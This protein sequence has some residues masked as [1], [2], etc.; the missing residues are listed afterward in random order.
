M[1]ALYWKRKTYLTKTRFQTCRRA[2]GDKTNSLLLI[3]GPVVGKEDALG[4]VVGDGWVWVEG[5][6]GGC[7][8]SCPRSSGTSLCMYPSPAPMLF[9]RNC[10]FLYLSF[11]FLRLIRRTWRYSKNSSGYTKFGFLSYLCTGSGIIRTSNG[12]QL[13]LLSSTL[14]LIILQQQA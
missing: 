10:R 4:P 11:G 9:I 2:K 7:S 5:P 3:Y 12:L 13:D 1:T 6:G 14:G 8:C